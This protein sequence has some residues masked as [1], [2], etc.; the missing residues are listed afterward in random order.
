MIKRIL[1][2]YEIWEGGAIFIAERMFK[3]IAVA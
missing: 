1:L 3:S 2:D